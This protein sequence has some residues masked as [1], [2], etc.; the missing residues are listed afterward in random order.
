VRVA[1]QRLV[2]QV[3]GLAP[4][5][6]QGGA[7]RPGTGAALPG[8]QRIEWR[9]AAAPSSNVSLGRGLLAGAG[10]CW[11]ELKDA[12]GLAE[13][14]GTPQR[15]AAAPL[16]ARGCTIR[17]QRPHLAF[18]PELGAGCTQVGCRLLVVVGYAGSGSGRGWGCASTAPT[19]S[20]RVGRCSVVC[21]IAEI[22]ELRMWIAHCCH[23]LVLGELAGKSSARACGPGNQWGLVSIKV[24]TRPCSCDHPIHGPGVDIAGHKE[25]KNNELGPWAIIV[26]PWLIGCK[27]DVARCW[28]LELHFRLLP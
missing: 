11:R 8:Q 16:V 2:P 26:P 27:L 15:P 12:G 21:R 6:C 7:A 23:Y 13:G 3:A 5:I 19:G 24:L 17:G 10:R 25:G 14:P 20:G 4:S 9:R 28:A 18:L 1:G 22:Y